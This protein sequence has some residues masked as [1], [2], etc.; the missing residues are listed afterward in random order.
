M[1][2]GTRE[3]EFR[4]GNRSV[5]VRARAGD[6]PA[7]LLAAAGMRVT[8]PRPVLVVCGGASDL[9]GEELA[10]TE[11]TLG[12]AVR[13]AATMTGAAVVD[14]G[15]D[16]GVM[17]L[18]GAA[19][20][21]DGEIPLLIGVA[22]AGLVALPGEPEAEA[23]LEPH[24]SHFV[25]ADCAAWGCET[26]LL[27]DVATALAGGGPLAM[28]LAGGG[29]VTRSEA[30]E[31]ARRGWPM[32]VLAGSGGASDELVALW[33]RYRDRRPR[34]LAAVLSERS[35][36]RRRPPLSAISDSALREVVA[37]GDVR[38]ASESDPT[39]LASRLAWELHTD[40]TLK[41]A[42]QKFATYDQ[43][44][45]RLRKSFERFQAA[46]LIL[47]V[48]ATLLAL[49]QA[50]IKNSAL[51][52]V[53]VALPIVGSVVIAIAN[54]RAAGK[55]WVMLRGAAESLKSEIFR[56][57]ARASP[58]ESD[59]RRAITLATRVDAVVAA[60]MRTDASSGPLTPY[61][62][63]LPPR[64]YGAAS[65]DGIT[66]LGP[67]GYLKTRVVAQLEYYHG[68]TRW[69]DRRRALLQLVAL[70]AGGAGAILA[71]ADVEAWIG[72]TTI[73]AVGGFSYLGTLQVDSTIVAYNQAAGR[74][75]TLRD[76]WNAL[77]ADARTRTAFRRLVDRAEDGLTTELG[78]WVEQMNESIRHQQEGQLERVREVDAGQ[79][80]T[81]L[82]G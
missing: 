57:R 1:S 61:A 21:V 8:V 82:P 74:L 5:V 59:A 78:G 38:V 35:R 73:I 53:V 22:P 54:R 12:P 43:L 55:R 71:A 69:L 4:D 34:R 72:L 36:E 42:W 11:R 58:Y 26:R 33:R 45:N 46:I 28:V 70:S 9:K 48:L 66:A 6:P 20:S 16:A 7:D 76:G 47:G 67:D 44:A 68:K 23:T 64:M 25:L 65:D 39:P 27:V 29:E 60:L 79:A 24:H 49:I 51:H 41:A 52:W 10:H 31:A 13:A 50:S 40:V 56:Y 30:V 75:E 77:R 81:H 14:G 19:R 62:G 18:V 32:F 15:T 37:Q 63:P 3:V 80:D 2:I 17:S